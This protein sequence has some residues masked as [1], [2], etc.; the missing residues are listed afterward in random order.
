MDLDFKG[1][2]D[3]HRHHMTQTLHAWIQKPLFFNILCMSICAH[4]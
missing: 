4:R 1:K 3:I 2:I